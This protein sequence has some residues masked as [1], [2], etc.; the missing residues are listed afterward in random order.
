MNSLIE[1]LRQYKIGPFSIFDFVTAYLGLLI[2]SP[3]IIWLFAK[4]RLRITIVS[5]MW[6]VL[7]LSVVTHIAIGSDT[8]FTKMVLD[9]SGNYLAKI[10]ILVMIILGAWGISRIR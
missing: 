9:P 8:P 3:L 10:I 4:M 2:I 1:S 6:F 5:I 7:P